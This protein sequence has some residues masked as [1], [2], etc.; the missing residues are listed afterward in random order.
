MRLQRG[1][2]VLPAVGVVVVPPAVAFASGWHGVVS[3]LSPLLLCQQA[4]RLSSG[5][6]SQLFP[7]LSVQLYPG[8]G[9]GRLRYP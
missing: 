8:Q 1:G 2:L 7:V 3:R 4:C 5:K 9:R 6:A